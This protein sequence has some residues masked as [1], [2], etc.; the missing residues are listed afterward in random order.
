MRVHYSTVSAYVKGHRGAGAEMTLAQ[1]KEPDIGQRIG[2]QWK[3][4]RIPTFTEILELCRGKIGIYLD[5]KDASI[6]ALATLIRDYEMQ[7]DVV[8]C[9]SPS[10][11]PQ[12]RSACPECIE[13]PDPGPETN[14]PD[15]IAAL[16]PRML[17]PV[18][19]DFSSTYLDHCREHDIIVFVDERDSKSWK[20]AIAWG[21]HGIQTNDP[22]GL[23]QYLKRHAKSDGD[24][25]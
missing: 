19:K 21:A 17:A 25:P 10:E 24:I 11:V 5:I 12:L 13:M 9:L 6:P 1:L 3:G 18:W 4:T 15:V 16:D 2:D 20:N 23:I 22:E 14:V 7:N 8:W